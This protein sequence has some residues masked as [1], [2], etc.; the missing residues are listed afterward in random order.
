MW[1]APPLP[2]VTRQAVDLYMKIAYPQGASAAVAA[3]LKKLDDWTG[4]F[5]ANPVFIRSGTAERAQ[6]YTLRL[7]NH[8][9]PH[10]KFLIEAMPDGSHYFFRADA[11][12]MHITL[13]H[14]HSEYGAWRQLSRNN[15]KLAAQIETQWSHAALPTFATYLDED[16]T[17]R[18]RY[19]EGKV[20]AH[21]AHDPGS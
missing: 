10:M 5:Y 19:V 15:H 13:S 11:H 3:L 20:Y 8:C 16:L 1:S 14:D 18:E 2:S 17:Q 9:Y 6:C 21:A 7:G 12:D 4:E